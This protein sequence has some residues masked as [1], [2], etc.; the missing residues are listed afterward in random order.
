[1][2]SEKPLLLPFKRFDDERGYFQELWRD[3]GCYPDLVSADVSFVQDNFSHSQKNVL[4]GLHYQLQKP[5]GKLLTVLHGQI[6]D[7][8]VDLRKSKSTFG[9]I[10]RFELSSEKPEWLWIP[11]GFAHGFY[12]L[13]QRADCFYKCT[14]YFDPTDS[15]VIRWD[16]PTLNILWPLIEEKPVLSPNDANGCGFIKADYFL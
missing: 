15:H 5:Q 16:D 12:V 14:E 8:C 3:C 4:R 9:Q 10:Y 7:V 6:F 11:P 2:N 1:M 13:S